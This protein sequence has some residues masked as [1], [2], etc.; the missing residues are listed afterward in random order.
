MT[1]KSVTGLRTP[2]NIYGRKNIIVLYVCI[3]SSKTAMLPMTTARITLSFLRIHWTVGRE[4]IIIYHVIVK[5]CRHLGSLNGKE[6]KKFWWKTYPQ[7]Q[8]NGH[9]QNWKRLRRQ[10]PQRKTV[11]MLKILLP[12]IIQSGI[13][14]DSKTCKCQLTAKSMARKELLVMNLDTDPTQLTIIII[15]IMILIII[16][17]F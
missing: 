16:I 5:N 9:T 12:R 6:A 14:G 17:I 10:F 11:D 8:Y 7:N 4:N 15:I 2:K 13:F 1:C 3:Q